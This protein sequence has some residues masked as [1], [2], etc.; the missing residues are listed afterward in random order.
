MK[1]WKKGQSGEVQQKEVINMSNTKRKPVRNGRS[2]ILSHSNVP[3][4]QLIDFGLSGA[5][6]K[7]AMRVRKDLPYEED[8]TAPRIDAKDLWS[9]I[10]KPYGRF[11]AWADHYIKPLIDGDTINAEICAFEDAS[12]SGK[13]SKHYKL[14]RNLAVHLSMLANTDEGREIRNYFIDMESIVFR[15]AEYNQSR[16]HT[17]IKLDNR[18][19]HAAY[20]R[21]PERAI[22]HER[23][24]KSYVCKVLTGLSAKEVQ[25]K[26]R[27]GI[28]DVLRN[29]PEQ[30]DIYCD[31]LTLAIEMYKANKE[32]DV[33]TGPL[34]Q[35]LYGGKIDLEKLLAPQQ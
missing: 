18:M 32:W 20:K 30:L 23:M 12:K 4:K 1:L 8:P 15:L 5:R 19:T 27:M 21:K 10:G 3:E 6:A 35:Q 28:R 16:V 25:L 29:H 34:L 17:P 22:D 26:Y 9:K 31:A 2:L 24:M 11:R 13:P 7:R 33:E 14:S